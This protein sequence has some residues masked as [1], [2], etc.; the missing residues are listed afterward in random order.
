MATRRN[1]K[2]NIDHSQDAEKNIENSWNYD[3]WNRCQNAYVVKHLKQQ[4]WR[5]WQ[6]EG[7]DP[8]TS[9]TCVKVKIQKYRHVLWCCLALVLIDDLNGGF[10]WWRFTEPHKRKYFCVFVFSPSGV[11]YDSKSIVLSFLPHPNLDSRTNNFSQSR[12]TWSSPIRFT[13]THSE[14]LHGD[15]D[16][17]HVQLMGQTALAR[18]II[19][20]NG[21]PILILCMNC[22]GALL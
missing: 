2:E 19:K 8:V 16:L 4:W 7:I 17:L 6:V 22:C 12:Q 18:Y 13:R 3:C 14:T 15:E 21:E 11:C 5:H 1:T 20:E 10:V 9:N